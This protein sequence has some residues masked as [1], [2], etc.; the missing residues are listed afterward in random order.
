VSQRDR[1]AAEIIEA[2]RKAADG[3]PDVKIRIRQRTTNPLQRFMRGS[4]GERL[5]VQIRGHELDIAAELGQRVE[6]VMKQVP[7][8]ADVRNNRVEGLE[9]RTVHIDTQR[10]A[11]VGVSRAEVA[12]TLET[13]VL[14]RVATRLRDGGDEYDVRVML[15]EQD[16]E[17]TAQLGQLPILTPTGVVPL[18]SIAEVGV[19]RGPGSIERD[20]QERVL[21]ISGG[22][23]DRPLSEVVADL[24]EALARIELPAG[25][26]IQLAGESREQKSTFAGLQ[27]GIVLA[28]FLVFAVMAVQFESLR[29][30]LIVMTSVPFGFVGVVL[31]LVLTGTTFSL[32]AFLGS[33]VLVGIAVNNA[34]VLVDAANLLRREHGLDTVSAVVEA[35]RRRLRPILMTTS[36]TLLGVLPIALAIGEGSEIQAPLA[37]VVLGGLLVSTVITLVLL[38]ALYVLT[39]RRRA[40]A[41]PTTSD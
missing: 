31:T 28:I 1:G 36:T 13:Y 6:A 3:I 16:R 30:P 21:T 39:D 4:Q 10:A 26:S 32:N 22:L 41:S 14:G 23:G 19:R 38:P 37:R 40:P 9:E 8:I 12:R 20:G 18:S 34:I 15:R 2:I 5:V 17:H 11:D 27:I 33:I 24:E 29:D 35:G 25:F 7:G